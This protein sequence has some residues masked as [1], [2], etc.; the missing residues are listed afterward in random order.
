MQTGSPTQLLICL[1]PQFSYT[2]KKLELTLES[3]LTDILRCPDCG[4]DLDRSNQNLACTNCSKRFPLKGEILDLRLGRHDYYFNPVP[5]EPMRELTSRI[6]NEPWADVIETFLEHVNFNQDW[7]D[8]LVAAGR[9]SWKLFLPLPAD[10]AALDL[11]CGLGNLSESLAPHIA[12]LYSLDLTFERLEFTQER[13]KKFVPD[14]NACLIAGGDGKRLPFADNSLDLVCLS[15]VL[16]WIPDVDELWASSDNK[17]EKLWRMIRVNIGESNPKRMQQHFLRDIGRV[18][19]PEGKIFIAIENRHNY[20]YFL[21]RPDHHSTLKYGAL[22]PRWAANLYSIQRNRRPYRTYTHGYTGY[23]KLLASAG[24]SVNS[25]IGLYEGYSHLKRL[26][27]FDYDKFCESPAPDQGFAQKF[28][29]SKYTSPAYGIIANNVLEDRTEPPLFID[30]LT[31]QVLK[32]ANFEK[33]DCCFSKI[34]VS[35]KQ[36]TILKLDARETSI[37]VKLPWEAHTVTQEENNHN[38]IS[39][40]NDFGFQEFSFPKPIGSGNYQGLRYFAESWMIGKNT[41]LQFQNDKISTLFERSFRS[42]SDLRRFQQPARIRLENDNYSHYVDSRI[43]KISKVC[44]K[45]FA[46]SLSNIA[47]EH[48]MERS[49]SIGLTHGDFS[50]SNFLYSN[51]SGV[52]VMLDWEHCED[53]GIIGLDELNYFSSLGRHTGEFSTL[54]DSVI[55][56]CE[57]MTS[58][59]GREF[60]Q[61][62]EHNQDQFV[63]IENQRDWKAFGFLYWLDHIYKQ[64]DTSMRFNRKWV[65][66]NIEKLPEMLP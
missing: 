33:S 15:G 57:G 13:L 8:N 56:I 42:L 53:N 6:E 30:R 49:V 19:K 38:W 62:M 22:L 9:Y 14:A 58:D 47:K 21:G 11:G 40:L 4:G 51:T 46:K 18:L 50:V 25:M 43:E 27:P 24:F 39:R 26:R 32:D 10:T 65:Q 1:P 34:F 64:L 37:A 2:A 60:R 5:R 54:L 52:P 29:E 31:D 44:G 41:N 59:F 23:K 28:K 61:A 66:N 48:L 7:V 16:E 55:E 17:W 35:G 20:E 45:E 12:K 36:K 63:A 3:K